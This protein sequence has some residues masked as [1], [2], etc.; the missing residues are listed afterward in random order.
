MT[1]K[2]DFLVSK[3]S[4][5]AV[6]GACFNN[7]NL[8]DK[9]IQRL[10]I[11]DFAI[12]ANRSIYAVIVQEHIAGKAFD[13][14]S[15]YQKYSKVLDDVG[16]SYLAEIVATNF[17]NAI[18]THVENVKDLSRRR[19]LLKIC[20]EVEESCFDNKNIDDIQADV[21]NKMLN[22]SSSKNSIL[23]MSD[24]LNKT[25]EEIEIAYNSDGGIVGVRTGYKNFDL[26]TNGLKKGEYMVIGARPS[27][28][29]TAITLNLIAKIDKKSKAMLVETDMSITAIGTR[30][31]ALTSY[32]ENGKL[33]RGLLSDDEYVK[34]G[35]VSA[36]QA[37]KDNIF[38]TD[39]S[40]PRVE[41]IYAQA[42][43]LKKTKGLDVV[44]ID[45]IGKLKA[46]SNGSRYEQVTEVS[47][48]LKKL[49]KDLDICVIALC[50]LNRSVEQRAD[51]RP[52]LSDL[53][54]TGAIEEDADI[55]GFLYR[56]GYYSER[57]NQEK[58]TTD[59]LELDF[60]KNRNGKIGT[61]YFDYNLATQIIRERR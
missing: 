13:S 58:V 37:S 10:D 30:M 49:A 53:R 45:H 22:V 46:K 51:K 55:I 40:N 39:K 26:L 8:M 59:I 18:D 4:E 56:D 19:S 28:G 12:E 48:S 1:N 32:I 31:L 23:S 6:L 24:V 16:L 27:M 35:K 50:Q 38:F 36:H 9:V 33:A 47:N 25:F 29:K 61:I 52:M 15:I 42:K 43:I 34:I 7:N 2:S 41:E 17:Q 11:N 57:E 20:E 54:D 44:V 60:Q 5:I 21:I 14:L 3:D